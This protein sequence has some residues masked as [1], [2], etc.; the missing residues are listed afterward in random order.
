MMDS[1]GQK[2]SHLEPQIHLR[3][4]CICLKKP[5]GNIHKGEFFITHDG[6]LSFT[7]KS[8]LS[9]ALP[10]FTFSKIGFANEGVSIAI[11]YAE[12]AKYLLKTT[13]G[14]QTQSNIVATPEYFG[15]DMFIF[16]NSSIVVSSRYC[17]YRSS[18]LGNSWIPVYY[19]KQGNFLD[20]GNGKIS[21]FLHRIQ[22]SHLL[23]GVCH[24]NTGLIHQKI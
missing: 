17:I 10:T 7:V 9:G 24:G 2:I 16:I 8:L 4:L 13:D 6:G 19:S 18:D 22:C 5:F 12:T 21:F 15:G 1:H 20:H 11:Y 3:I 23:T 14:W